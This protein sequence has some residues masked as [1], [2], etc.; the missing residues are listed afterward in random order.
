MINNWR[1]NSCLIILKIISSHSAKKTRGD[2]SASVEFVSTLNILRI[3]EG[4]FCIITKP[5]PQTAFPVHVISGIRYNR[6]AV[7]PVVCLTTETP[8][9]FKCRMYIA[10]RDFTKIEEILLELFLENHEY[11][12]SFLKKNAVK[13]ICLPRILPDSFRMG[14]NRSTSYFEWIN[15]TTF[16]TKVFLYWQSFHDDL[17]FLIQLFRFW[18]FQTVFIWAMQSLLK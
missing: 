11:S 4:A 9:H 15:W 10:Q 7:N 5:L 13:T 17:T 6:L 3:Q 18:P 14:R 12:R 8:L 16:S 2:S 1:Y